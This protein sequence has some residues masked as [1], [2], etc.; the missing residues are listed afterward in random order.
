MYVLLKNPNI[1][2]ECDR[3][4]SRHL[5]AGEQN[6]IYYVFTMLS[7]GRANSTLSSSI[8]LSPV[9]IVSSRICSFILPDSRQG[10]SLQGALLE[11]PQ[12]GPGERLPLHSPEPVSSVQLLSDVRLFVTHGL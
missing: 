8:F 5:C 3:Q 11:M 7:P 10:G 9:G 4:Y 6:Q 2:L 1:S 12:E